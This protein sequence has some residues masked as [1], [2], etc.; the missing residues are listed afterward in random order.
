M[1]HLWSITRMLAVGLVV[2]AASLLTLPAGAHPLGNN[3]VSRQARLALSEHGV[4]LRYRMDFAEIPT[5]AAAD[6]ADFD[7][8]G[9]TSPL[10]WRRF[11]QAS[12]RE[13]AT[14]LRLEIDGQAVQWVSSSAVYRLREGEAGLQVLQLEVLLEAPLTAAGTHHAHYRDD[15]RPRDLGWKEVFVAQNNSIRIAGEVSHSDRSNGLTDYPK[16]GALLQELSA[17]FEFRWL[18]VSAN[19]TAAA[20]PAPAPTQPRKAATLSRAVIHQDNVNPAAGTAIADAANM[21]SGSLVESTP[22]ALAAKP[23]RDSNEHAMSSP[24]AFFA[25]GIHHIATGLDHLAF[26]LG[27]LL[28]APRM[29]EAIKL[30]SAFTVAHS[31]TLILAAGRWLAPPGAWVE[32]AI[33]F[34][35]AYVGFVAWRRRPAGHGLALAFLFGLVHGFGFAGALAESLGGDAAQG[36]GWLLKLLCFN[37]GIEAFQLVIVGGALVLATRLRGLSWH[38]AAHSAASLAVLTCGLAWLALRLIEP[39]NVPG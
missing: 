7:A 22:D 14:K 38:S 18:P 21:P 15:F 12:S 24:A 8:D 20:V 35:I 9:A 5:L 19:L 13:L 39:A 17:D 25:L 3:T 27:L 36:Q 6:E 4:A 28:L 34:T 23:P 11:A 16:N 31:I 29:R 10:E 2:L 33:A 26:L 32:P 37:L 1:K 30:V